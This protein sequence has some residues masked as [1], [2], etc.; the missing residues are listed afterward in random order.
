VHGGVAVAVRKEIVD[1][2]TAVQPAQPREGRDEAKLRT[3]DQGIA[4]DE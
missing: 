4:E 3:G 1:G 2:A